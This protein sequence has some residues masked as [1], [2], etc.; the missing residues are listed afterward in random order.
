MQSQYVIT[1]IG[2]DRP[3][4]VEAVSS[5]VTEH[6]GNWLQGKLSQLS[7]KFAGLVLIS[8]PEDRAP[9]LEQDLKDLDRHGLSVRLTASPGG[10]MS[11]NEPDI[12][13]SIVGPDRPGIVREVSSALADCGVNVIEMTTHVAS[14]P[15]TGEALFEASVTAHL[16]ADND[17]DLL[18]DNLDRIANDMTLDIDIEAIH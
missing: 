16:G 11:A 14:A 17:R 7:C 4:L 18:E 1:F 3:G 2:D 13:L 12:G 15:M 6:G 8:L 10:S 9:A 5:A